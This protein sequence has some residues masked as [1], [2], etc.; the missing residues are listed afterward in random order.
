MCKNLIL[1]KYRHLIDRVA[2]DEGAYNSIIEDKHEN[3]DY[4]GSD[5]R[6]IRWKQ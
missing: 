2:S 3:S 1:Y 4:V 6:Y 5:E